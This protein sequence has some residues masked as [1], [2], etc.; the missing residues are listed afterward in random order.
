[1]FAAGMGQKNMPPNIV[2]NIPNN[3]NLIVLFWTDSLGGSKSRNVFGS[4]RD[5]KS[6]IEWKESKGYVLTETRE[7]TFEKYQNLIDNPENP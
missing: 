7:M 3:T 4:S 2:S 1:M 6:F 5:I